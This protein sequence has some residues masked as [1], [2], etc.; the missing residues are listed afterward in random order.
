MSYPNQSAQLA[1][2]GSP[3]HFGAVSWTQPAHGGWYPPHPT[4][5]AAD[6]ATG[7][8]PAAFTAAVVMG[9]KHM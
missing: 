3:R 8:L 5:A 1:A 4:G 2:Q 9:N 7:A 6:S